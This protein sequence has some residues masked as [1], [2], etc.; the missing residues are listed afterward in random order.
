MIN[1]KKILIKTRDIIVIMTLILNIIDVKAEVALLSNEVDV[2]RA[3]LKKRN[4]EKDRVKS[5]EKY[6]DSLDKY[7]EKR[8]DKYSHIEKH[9]KMRR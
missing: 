2:H 9:T 3:L 6:Y 1:A 5:K 8:S 7:S 4:K